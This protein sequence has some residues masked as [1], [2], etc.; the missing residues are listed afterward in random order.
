MRGIHVQDE[1]LLESR[2]YELETLREL[3]R[4]MP[5]GVIVYE[6]VN[7]GEDFRIIY[8][9][10]AM[11][12]AK[13][14][15][16]MPG[17]TYTETW[18]EIAHIGLPRL[19]EVLD[20]GQPRVERG[21]PLEVEISPG[22]IGT[23][24]YTYRVERADLGGQHLLFLFVN[25]V[26]RE[27]RVMSAIRD[28]RAAAQREA[29]TSSALLHAADELSRPSGTAE[30]ADVVAQVLL[31]SLG[32]T[33]ASVFLIDFAKERTTVIASKGR[34]PLPRGHV[35][36]SDPITGLA[37]PVRS[38]EATV[39]DFQA[40][41]PKYR[42]IADRFGT[43]VALIAP[44]QQ[45]GNVFGVVTV[46]DPGERKEFTDRDVAFAAGIASQAALAIQNA[47][48]LE[49]ARERSVRWRVLAQV[50]E[51][52]SSALEPARVIDAALSVAEQRLGAIAT[53]LWIFHER[54]GLVTLV[55]ARGF[56]PDFMAEYDPG[57]P[58]DASFPVARAV[59][60][61]AP[62]LFE[63]ID[64]GS[65]LYAPVRDA[66]ARY[67]ITL[68]SLAAVPLMTGGRATG[69]ITLA[70]DRER[71]FDEGFVWFLTTLADHF[72]RVLENAQQAEDLATQ[73]RFAEA[74]NRM[75]EA[76]HATLSADEVLESIAEGM[77]E[78][79]RVDAAVVQVRREGHRELAYARGA[80][81][82]LPRRLSEERT[83]LS[84]RI[85]QTGEPVVIDDITTDGI[86]HDSA[87][88]D[89][90]LRSVIGLPIFIRSDVIGAIFVGRQNV[91]PFTHR[92]VEFAR[93]AAAAAS[94]AMENA[95][96]YETQQRLA[97]RLQ[98]ALLSLPEV[99]EG[100][101]FAHEYRSAT[102]AARV[103]GDF[104]DVFPIDGEYIGIVMGDVA[105]KG[106]EA[107][108]LTSVVRST[109]RAHLSEC[110]IE[111][112]PGETLAAVNDVLFKSTKPESFVTVFF[113]VLDRLTGTLCYSNAG[114]TTTML[115]DPR[116]A[117]TPL[118]TT[119]VILGAFGHVEVGEA[120][121]RFGKGDTLVLY[122]DGLTEARQD[123]EMYGEERVREVLAGAA[124]D[125]P[126]SVVRSV[127]QD[128]L[129]FGDGQLS[130]DVALLV[131]KRTRDTAPSPSPEGGNR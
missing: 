9:N 101:E 13:P 24:H 30:V 127:M 60:D 70:W 3:L 54:R 108:V 47:R 67:G 64:S 27:Q 31:D 66:Y 130:D 97:D 50:A 6:P 1:V 76:F 126:E 10:P 99:V 119:G 125:P 41:P 98:Q 7:D 15:R 62:V 117:I 71:T 52:T 122:T 56:P 91:E 96:L 78:A 18:P 25:D 114:H 129:S 102:V 84:A 45:G 28:A 120:E 57:V 123:G 4:R 26:T 89:L 94:L 79:L 103:G 116:G 128:V 34:E 87:L 75:N 107:A 90:G 58:L 88:H 69:V 22:E 21:A 73:A 81:A 109:I 85:E 77:S 112:S 63:S 65:G 86:A 38:G 92:E 29:E 8:A 20:T 113:G 14:F 59:R 19:R 83:P 118:G 35:L 42:A 48:S 72:S 17:R 121:V 33:R 68:R 40:L 110:R 55:A 12:A 44:I 104:Y 61:G 49:S 37:G 39:F 74:L 43:S 111:P 23:R 95:S 124:S 100:L 16:R 2:T 36:K 51:L 46:D 131:L 80:P 5:T 53:S 11:E 106:L 82:P 105:G 115:V 32:H 93:E